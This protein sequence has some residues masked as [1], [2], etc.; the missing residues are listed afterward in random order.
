MEGYVQIYTGKGKTTASLF[1]II[2]EKELLDLI[3]MKPKNVEL[4][5]TG[6][7]ATKKIIEKADLV[8]E[9]KEIRLYYKQGVAARVGIEK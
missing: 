8:T 1:N 2:T 4:V 9:I 5:I 3:D 6:R 7:G